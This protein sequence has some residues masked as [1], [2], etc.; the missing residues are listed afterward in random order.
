VSISEQ[1]TT[2]GL[3]YV[4]ALDGKV[5]ASVQHYHVALTDY[6]ARLE[7]ELRQLRAHLGTMAKEI[8]TL[9]AYAK[10]PSPDTRETDYGAS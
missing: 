3:Y 2:A 4:H 9:R 1:P 8:R 5:D 10:L 7:G 6:V